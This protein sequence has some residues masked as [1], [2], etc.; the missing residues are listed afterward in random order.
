MISD[1]LKG[2]K[3]ISDISNKD[4]KVYMRDFLSQ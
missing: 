1:E 4:I 2:K 3:L